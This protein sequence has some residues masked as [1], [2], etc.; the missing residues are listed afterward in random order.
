MNEKSADWLASC[1]FLV[2]SYEL[3]RNFVEATSKKETKKWNG[4]DANQAADYSPRFS[5]SSKS[6]HMQ[7]EKH[8]YVR[9]QCRRFIFT[10]LD[11]QKKTGETKF[12][13]RF[14]ISSVLF[15]ISDR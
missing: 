2:T 14:S 4:E 15:I 13:T 11:L 12:R 1:L 10:W 5:I 7:T 6:I 8:A 3:L 9:I